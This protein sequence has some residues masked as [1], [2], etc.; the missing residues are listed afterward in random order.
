MRRPPAG[1]FGSVMPSV[2]RRS[3]GVSMDR[4]TARPEAAHQFLKGF[5]MSDEPQRDNWRVD[6]K[7]PNCGRQGAAK[8][9]EEDYPFTD[10]RRF[11]VDEVTPGFSVQNAGS[12]VTEMEIACSD[13]NVSARPT[14]PS[15]AKGATSARAR[16]EDEKSL[17][18]RPLT[19]FRGR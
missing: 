3:S 18:L 16:Q 7:C 1:R 14:D 13:C 8:V 11:S 5:I 15:S 17:H 19:Y 9:S 6:L 4:Q 10:N 2:P 12:I